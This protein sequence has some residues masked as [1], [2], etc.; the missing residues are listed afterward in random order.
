MKNK[1]INLR[2]MKKLYAFGKKRSLDLSLSEN[3]LGCSPMVSSAF[4]KLKLNFNDYPKVNGGSLKKALSKKLSINEKL[5]FIANGSES[6]INMIPR[7][8]CKPNDEVIIPQLTFPMFKT[9][10][11]LAGLKTKL[12]KM[13]NNLEIDLNGILKRITNK[14]KL[15]FICNPNNPT[16]NVLSKNKLI[17]FL[18]K[19]PNSVLVVLDEANIEFAGETLINEVI[20]RRNLI[21]LRT[22]SKGFGLAN[23]RIGFAVASKLII[24]K[25]EEE[26]N[27]FPISGISEKLAIAALEDDL[28]LKKTKQFI[29]KERTFLKE[30]LSEIKFK[31]F[32]SQANNLFIKLPKSINKEVFL[33]EINK[34]D[35]SLV[36]GNNFGELD[37]QF[38]RISPRKRKINEEFLKRVKVILENKKISR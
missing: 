20:K 38:F 33:E 21:I 32:P 24:N 31:V 11:E 34:S 17:S 22:F 29:K 16:G 35:I 4:K 7:I 10:S 23:L 28:F 1:K 26:I 15:I 8:L 36:K 12:I 2:G 37:N 30:S 27:I 18:N 14:T 6:I 9:C 3:P 13:K 19:V 5:F 25:L